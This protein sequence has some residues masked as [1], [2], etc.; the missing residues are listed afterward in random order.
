MT[1]KFQTYCFAPNWRYSPLY[2]FFSIL[3]FVPLSLAATAPPAM[4]ECKST[5]NI[6]FTEERPQSSLKDPGWFDIG[7]GVVVIKNAGI[8]QQNGVGGMVSLRAYPF[9]RWYAAPIAADPSNVNKLAKAASAASGVTASDTVA[10]KEAGSNL[11]QAM[12][13]VNSDLSNNYAICELDTWPHLLKRVSF[14]L[15]RSV[16]GFDSNA[17][18]GDINAFG[19]AF[20]IAPQFSI[21]YGRAYFNL[22]AQTGVANNTK[23]G[24]VFGVQINLNAFKTMRGITGS[25]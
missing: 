5:N 12:Q 23:S 24:N 19:I 3:I 10:N 20:D 9:G 11:E 8:A 7:A 15:G 16:G 2:N 1:S 13:T 17:V 4:A 22:P 25:L 14:F 6:N 21:V 18:S